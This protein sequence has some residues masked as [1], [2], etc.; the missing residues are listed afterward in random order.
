MGKR[1]SF[2]FYP[3]D[4]TGDVALQSC[5]LAAQG[6]WINILCRLHNSPVYGKFLLEQNSSKNKT[7]GSNLLVIKGEKLARVVGRPLQEIEPLIEELL[8]ACV[9]REA[10]S[11]EYYSKRMIEDEELREIRAKAGSLGGQKTQGFAQAKNEANHQ[12]KIK[13]EP[14]QNNKQKVPP[15]SSSSSSLFKENIDKRNF[16]KMEES[17]LQVW[18]KEHCKYLSKMPNQLTYDE[19]IKIEKKYDPVFIAGMLKKM[20]NHKSIEKNKYVYLTLL[21]WIR[22]EISRN[23]DPTLK[24]YKN[25]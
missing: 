25:L 13:K 21:T 8:E 23:T 19:A 6:L 7:E 9:M 22:N 14:K 18:I 17:K 20:D 12:A 3:N 10:E 11:G 24:I 15:S 1:P 4:W 16:E 5:S 2:Q